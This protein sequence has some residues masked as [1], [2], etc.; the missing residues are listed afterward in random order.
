ME[1]EFDKEMDSLL[2]QTAKGEKLF[3]A[4]NPRGEH[5]DADEISMF[6]ENALP[7]K[8]KP[9]VRKHLADCDRCRTILSNVI[10][11]NEE[12]ATVAVASIPVSISETVV[13]SNEKNWFQKLFS[14]RNLAFGMGALALVFAV[15]IGFI[16][17]QNLSNG[18]GD[19][20][21]SSSDEGF[22][23][24]NQ[25]AESKRSASSPAEGLAESEADSRDSDLDGDLAAKDSPLGEDNNSTG[26]VESKESA[27]RS[28]GGLEGKS[29]GR[30]ESLADTKESSIDE[31]VALD[32]PGRSRSDNRRGNKSIDKTTSAVVEMDD[33][34]SPKNEKLKDSEKKPNFGKS[35]IISKSPAKPK[36]VPPPPPVTTR[37]GTKR[38]KKV[39]ER[40]AQESED[41]ALSSGATAAESTKRQ[42]KG[43]TFNRKNGIWTDTAYKGQRTT[44]VKRNTRQYRNL[45]QGLQSI[46]NQL[47]GTVIVVWESK[48]FKIQ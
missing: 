6:A 35:D 48:A 19:L 32:Q 28:T 12:E 30:R 37:S 3:A 22:N 24:A 13:A 39:E 26:S 1:F 46:G 2:R 8:A 31:E 44:N 45:D 23:N 10:V 4:G 42:I 5:I 18:G 43:K 16:V 36:T 34:D 40:N 20:A 41:L 11:L 33:A 21:R 15:G 27:D 38:N 25:A 17:V 9:R 14:T 7:E 47:N 29:S